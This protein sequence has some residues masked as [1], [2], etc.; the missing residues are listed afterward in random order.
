MGKL[1]YY[2]ANTPLESWTQTIYDD[3]NRRVIVKSDIETVGDA[4]K[5]ATQFFDQL[6]RVRLTKTL[7]DAATQSATNETDGIKVQTR[8][9][10]VSGYTYQL[11]SNPFRAAYASQATNDA[12]MGWT[13]SKAVNTGR[14]SE[15]ETFSGAALPA[16]WG[17]NANSTGKVQTDIDANATT[18]TDQAGKQR[19]SITNALGQLTRV[20]EPDSN[21]NLGSTQAPNQAT[22][23]FY[24]TLGKMV[25]VQQGVQN[26]YF[27]YDSLGR[28]LRVKQPEQE[29]NTALNTTGNA[30][31]N[32]W[33][34]G[35][36]YDNN[37]N[38]L[39]T[40][41]AK[42]T[43]I[44]ST[45]DALNRPLMRTYSDGTPVVTNSYDDSSVPFSKGKLT[46][47][48]SSISETTY[49]SFDV[50]GRLLS[51]TQRTPLD[52][53]TVANAIPRTSSYQYNV[54]GVLTQQTYPSGRIVKHE[55]DASGDIARISGKPTSTATEQMYATGFAYFAD[56]K[57]E[58][59]KLGNGLWESAK[60][61]SRL[62]ATE[63]AMGHSV[64]D[65]GL[66]KLSYEYGELNTD[67]VTVDT[68][69]NAGNIAK[70]TV[71]FSGL[72]NPFVQT[73]KYDSLDRITEAIE[74]V[75]GVQTWKQTFGYDIY[76]NRNAF[77]QKVGEQELAMNNLTLP[78]VDANT[79]RFNGGQG[80]GYDKNGNVINDPASSGRT[81]IFDGDNKQTEVKN[82][83][84]VTIGRYY[85]N[86][87]GKRV[88]K[89][90][91]LETTIFVYDGL[92]KLVAEYST[93]T[94]PS[95]PTIN[96]TATDQLGSPRVLTDK[97]GN[98][99]SRRDFL[100]FGEEIYANSTANRTESNKYSLIG[101]DAVRQRF[102]GYERD[103]ESELDYAI[104]RY[105][106]GSHGRF[107]AVDPY[108]IIF[109]ME[110]GKDA[111]EKQR[112]FVVYISQPQ[113]WNKYA[114]AF[115][116]PLKYSDPDGRR[117]ITQQEE[118]NLRRFLASGMAYAN[119][120][121]DATQRQNFVNAV[122]A[123]AAAIRS[124]ITAVPND[125]K[126][127]PKNLRSVLYAMSQI[128]DPNNVAK[129]STG[130]TVRY[131]S[132]GAEVKLGAGSNKCTIFVGI[133]YA[134]RDGAN[135]GWNDINNSGGY[136]V[137]RSLR[138]NVYVPVANDLASTGMV[139]FGTVTNPQL[140]DVA[141]GHGTSSGLFSY[142]QGH[143]G[144]VVAGEV[145]ISANPTHGVR[146]G[147]F[148]PTSDSNAGF[149]YLRY[150]P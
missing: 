8:Y 129:W 15:V 47:V 106:N 38:V 26:R 64:G 98:V 78:S 149:Q 119:E 68:T 52:G 3:V 91:D 23:Y 10:T 113:I 86:G 41:D 141:A 84:N 90:T 80:Y 96:Y 135:I 134:S 137:N 109:E 60:L 65:G 33:T 57:I 43:T 79:N 19:R 150:K 71:N 127:D 44:T 102:T 131:N 58:R 9:K 100:P 115:N 63:I 117:P 11:T 75:N 94:P 121:T 95:N 89:V 118:D 111:E 72:A 142:N 48:T 76:G 128:G 122:N 114:Y 139:N 14:H 2:P 17:S 59:L 42:G 133:A 69:K 5:V 29:V 36:G 99:V 1:V 35:F 145:V 16:P 49:T 22:N 61:N 92:G 148:S 21:G 82:S 39:T 126:E 110:K 55:Y 30:D 37:G 27:M 40:T 46:K 4:R 120:I 123:A 93:A 138:G 140:G 62:Q 6:G 12:T 31:N 88:K 97:L 74:K 101:Q 143:A 144:I 103:N 87:E 104:N 130:G 70:H 45:Y 13:R 53:E 50:A 28:M 108:N 132:N 124:A 107:T 116:N 24:N 112:I 51:S 54:S 7:E 136:Q 66:M 146:V 125:A 56:G 34:A 83:S 77:Y 105:Y 20:D 85:Y 32:S 81:F 18:V 73:F 147:R 67:G 25:R